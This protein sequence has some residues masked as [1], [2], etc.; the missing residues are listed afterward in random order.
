MYSYSDITTVHLEMTEACNASCPMCARN[1][2]GGEVSPLLHGAELGIA[3]IERIF[4]VEF[5]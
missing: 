1:L 2:N 4:P 5:I 3:D